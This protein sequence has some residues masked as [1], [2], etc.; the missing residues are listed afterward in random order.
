MRIWA[1]IAAVCLTVY[2]GCANAAPAFREG[3]VYE[4]LTSYETSEEGSDGS[5]GTSSGY[6]TIVVKIVKVTNE[7]LELEY[8]LPVDYQDIPAEKKALAR[9]QFWQFPARI[10]EPTG[11]PKQLLNAAELER[12][13]DIWLSKAKIERSLCGRWYFTWDAFKVECDPQSVLAQVETFDPTVRTIRDGIAYPDDAALEP[14]ILKQNAA[15]TMPLSFSGSGP[16]DA[17]KIRKAAAEQ[18]VITSQILRNETTMEEALKQQANDKISGIV[19]VM[20]ETDSDG[21]IIKKTHT[22]AVNTITPDNVST[23]RIVTSVT[24]RKKILPKENEG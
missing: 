2:A 13:L 23:K 19:T 5:T 8:D 24:E 12:R 7:G 10:F 14:I 6:D 11:G 15:K 17:N 22:R 1:T 4:I 21:E 18:R 20:I 16:I 9:E 3:E